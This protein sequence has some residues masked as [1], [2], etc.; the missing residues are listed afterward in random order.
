MVDL[1]LTPSKKK[2]SV[3]FL[4]EGGKV[5]LLRCRHFSIFEKVAFFTKDMIPKI[6]NH[7]S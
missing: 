6:V 7:Q 2:Y 4:G 1:I 5:W 3:F